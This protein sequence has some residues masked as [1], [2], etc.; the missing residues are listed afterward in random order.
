[1]HAWIFSRQ[2]SVSGMCSKH[3][4]ESVYTA[5]FPLLFSAKMTEQLK[6]Q[7]C[8]RFCQ[9]LG[10]SQVE[11]IWKIQHIFG[12]DAMGITQI[13][14]W[15]N[16]FKN[17]HT[18]VE[19][20]ACS[21]R[22]STKQI[23]KLIDQL[24]TLVMQDHRVITRELAEVVGISTGSVHSI[25]TND[26]AMR[27]VSAK[28]VL[29]ML[30]MKQKQ[31]CLEVSQDMLD[32]T[33]SD[34]EFQNIVTTGDESWVYRYDP[35]TK[36]QSSQWKHSTSLRPKKARQVRSNAKVTLTFSLTP[37]GWCITSMHH[38]AKILT[39]NTTWK[40]SVT[41]VILC[42]ARDWTCGQQEHG[43]FIMTTHQL[44]PQN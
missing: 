35:E 8:I 42:G 2:Q 7:Y 15:Y 16:Q 4:S 34:P 31:L 20:D 30:M 44:I 11:I 28:F 18:S 27:R 26:L 41:F 32:Y 40:S 10:D 9:K 5:R 29:N 6:Q 37:V 17:G 12:D 1:M 24:W 38:K 23:D 39:N 22:F 33:N 36:V 13:K 21:G 19:S 43:I 25:L 3:V 14:E